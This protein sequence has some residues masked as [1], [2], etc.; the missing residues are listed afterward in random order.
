MMKRCLVLL[1]IALLA[2]PV[3]MATGTETRISMYT[4]GEF[5]F[6]VE[7][8]LLE[9]EGFTLWYPAS[10]YT[11]SDFY[12]HPVLT[13]ANEEIGA[14]IT[15]VSSEIQP[16]Q[17]DGMILESVGGYGPEAAIGEVSEFEN[18]AGL[19]VLTVDA[20]MEEETHRF[21]LVVGEESTL[22]ITVI[23]PA[24]S[25]EGVASQIERIVR[26]VES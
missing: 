9:A 19:R 7:E 16:E 25:G 13:S 5:T 6:E 1:L 12:G 14:S 4:N 15:F 2:L 23:L 11:L 24:D 8:T 21:Y 18:A 20:V 3:C 22:C 17:A 10:S 26:S